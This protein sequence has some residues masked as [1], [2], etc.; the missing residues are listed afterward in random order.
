MVNKNLLY[1]R[2]YHHFTAGMYDV[3]SE[4]HRDFREMSVFTVAKIKYK[5]GH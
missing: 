3:S 5:V 4:K 1:N 2:Y